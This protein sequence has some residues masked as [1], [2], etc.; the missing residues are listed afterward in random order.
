MEKKGCLVLVVETF[1]IERNDFKNRLNQ[2]QH[3]EKT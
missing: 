1:L 2:K 3:H